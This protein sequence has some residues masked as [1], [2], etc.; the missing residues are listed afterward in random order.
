MTDVD[1]LQF[2][3]KLPVGAWL[4]CSTP[5][6]YEYRLS[7]DE[8]VI[9]NVYAARERFS[10][11]AKLTHG[12]TALAKVHLETA[13]KLS[14]NACL[15]EAQRVIEAPGRLDLFYFGHNHRHKILL[16]VG[17]FGRPERVLVVSYYD[18]TGTRTEEEFRG[19]SRVVMESFE[20]K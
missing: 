1:S 8:Q 9:C 4:D 19:R 18:Y 15:F 3:L 20:V 10:D 2:R 13:Q 11:A 17:V 6:S 16:H 7:N 5:A 14:G 12:A